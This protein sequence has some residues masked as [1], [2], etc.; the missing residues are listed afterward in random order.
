M[1]QVRWQTT[2]VPAGTVHLRVRRVVEPSAPPVLLLHGLGVAADVW[3]AFGRRLAPRYAA[4]APDLRGHGESDAPAHGYDPI[5]YARDLVALFGEL[6]SPPAPIVGHSLGSLVALALA[7]LRPDLAF[8]LVL[9]DP[10]LDAAT[11][12][13]DAA[14]VFRLRHAPTGELEGYLLAQNPRGGRLLAETLARLFRRSADGAF[15]ALLA[16]PPGHP[17]AWEWARRV[18]VPTLV[19]QADPAAGGVL[20]DAAAET[21]TRALPRGRLTKLPGASHAVHASH[22][23]ELAKAILDFLA[24]TA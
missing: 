4:V 1:V 19:V 18:Q 14:E 17:R 12:S 5:D 11:P 20:G 8:A 15:E 22:P 9:V 10:P 24:A 21:L 2:S 7:S 23:A 3:Q 6:V 16:E 13:R